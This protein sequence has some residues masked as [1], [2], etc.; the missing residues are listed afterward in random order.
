VGRHASHWVAHFGSRE[1]RT[2]MSWGILQ[3]AVGRVK[4]SEF[5]K[6]VLSKQTWT[7]I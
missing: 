7:V 5:E 1:R 4:K 2:A 3:P 6:V